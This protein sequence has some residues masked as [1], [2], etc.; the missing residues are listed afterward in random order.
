M[1]TSDKPHAAALLPPGVARGSATRR[2]FLGGATL[3]F[4]AGTCGRLAAAG[5]SGPLPEG[6]VP[7]EAEFWTRL[8]NNA[9][10]CDL[11]PRHC[12]VA[13]GKRGYCRVRENRGGSYFTLVHSRPC[14]MHLDP[15]EKKPFFHV[16]PGT[17]AF[18]LAT[19]G[20]NL[21]CKFCQNW[22][23]AQA[24][25]EDVPAAVRPP[26]SI[27]EAAAR[28]GA[29]TLAFTYSEPTVFYEYMRDCAKAAAGRGIHSI[30]ISN[31]F[32]NEAP[33]RA[34]LPHLKAVKI[35]LKAFTQSFY[36]DVCDG[37]LAPVLETLKII[38]GSGVWLEIVCLVIPTLNDHPQELQ[39]LAA[40]VVKE[41]GP[42]VPLHFTR[43]QPLYQL[44]NLPPTPPATLL[45]ARDLA[46]Q[47]GCRFV[48]TGNV[49]GLS[50]QDTACP[51]CGK[52][53]V[54]RYSYVIRENL[55][56]GNRC[57]SCQRVIPGAWEA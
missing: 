3:A 54:S 38:A 46:L 1:S 29:R 21:H 53:L 22:D 19:V 23:I 57:P 47:E 42:D 43:Y 6:I 16:L 26:D 39:R 48:Y 24:S 20:C 27:A 32:I 45:R 5:A 55:L 31:G 49:P 17:K 36:G 4:L 56:R 14:A 8:D 51:F 52:T 12:R 7:R 11:C 13:E 35:D 10:R 44:R 41:L 18:S 28:A 15:I 50:G 2:Q 37:L 9:I 25:P 33:L 34:L 40:W 30:L